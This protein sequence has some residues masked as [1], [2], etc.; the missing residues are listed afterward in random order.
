LIR[1]LQG[2]K[3]AQIASGNNHSL[4]LDADGYVYAWGHAGYSRLGLDDTKDRLIPT[5]VAKFAGK[6]P[7]D[8]AKAIYCGMT[9]SVIIEQTGRFFMAGKW[10]ISGD[11]GVGQ[12]YT[13]F[14]RIQ[15]I[16]VVDKVALG[17][18]THLVTCADAD[19]E[20]GSTMTLGFGQ[21][22]LYGELGFGRDRPLGAAL[23]TR[24]TDLDGCE[25][26]DIGAATFFTIFI[27]KPKPPDTDASCNLPVWPT[28]EDVASAGLCVICF[29]KRD[30]ALDP[31]VCEKV[32]HT[33]HH[34]NHQSR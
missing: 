4:A 9:S 20:P 6:L 14:K 19:D 28:P 21:G 27:V 32:D 7:R 17:G 8:R 3:I 16:S 25:V 30:E 29:S 13:T 24:V 12:P 31:V 34:H 23:P 15:D 5:L 33:L 18:C 11:G 10:K 1:G 22:V 2:K 26:L